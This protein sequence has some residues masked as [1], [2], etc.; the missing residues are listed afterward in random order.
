MKPTLLIAV[1]GVAIAGLFGYH[2]I[3]VRQQEQVRL[4]QG[5]IEQ[6][7][8]NQQARADVA[9]L[10]QEFER[11]RQRLPAE[12]DPS[13]LV[14]EAVELGEQSGV[15]LKSFTQDAPQ[16]FQKFT[17]LSVT[18]QLRA[19]YHQLGMFLDRV[20]RSDHYLHVDSLDVSPQRGEED[21]DRA[22]I[23]VV[24]STIH[25]PPVRKLMGT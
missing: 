1:I 6:E 8:A 9:A 11:Y 12:P 15:D 14:R 25:L 16:P 21:D 19:S 22:S 18:L 17:R 24:L 7:R 5:Q 2:G 23:K 13:W 3:Y 10:V 20:E 4:I